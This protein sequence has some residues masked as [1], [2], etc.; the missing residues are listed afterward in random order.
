MGIIEKAAYVAGRGA[1]RI[2]GT[3]KKITSIPTETVNS[4][5]EGRAGS[6]AAYDTRSEGKAREREMAR[7][8]KQERNERTR[9]EN[10]GKRIKAEEERVKREEAT[11]AHRRRLEEHNRKELNIQRKSAR[12]TELARSN[13]RRVERA[14]RPTSQGRSQ[15]PDSGFGGGL[16]NLEDALN[17]RGGKDLNKSMRDMEDAFRGM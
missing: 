17:G 4:Y 2:T 8:E 9:L 10:E 13:Q 5:K 3:V 14:N 16:S 6:V 1:G 15:S 11:Q 12:N 7:A